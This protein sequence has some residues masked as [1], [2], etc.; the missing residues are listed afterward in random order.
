[1]GPQHLSPVSNGLKVLENAG[2]RGPPAREPSLKGSQGHGYKAALKNHGLNALLGDDASIQP[3][4]L[5]ELMLND[6]S[7]L[8]ERASEA[9][10]AQEGVG[11]D[12]GCVSVTSQ[13]MR[14]SHKRQ[15]RCKKRY[16]KSSPAAWPNCLVAGATALASELARATNKSPYLIIAA[17]RKIQMLKGILPRLQG[18][19][20]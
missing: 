20:P 14:R 8:D 18:G 19:T 13:S 2:R 11:G 9:N 15:A 3:G 17:F 7:I 10:G 12:S 4:Q 16:A 1:M 5:R 6:R